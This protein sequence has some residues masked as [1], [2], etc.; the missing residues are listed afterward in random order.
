MREGKKHLKFFIDVAKI[1]WSSLYHVSHFCPYFFSMHTVC[2]GSIGPFYKVTYY[3]KSVT[4]SW[5]HSNCKGAEG[6]TNGKEHEERERE[7][8][9]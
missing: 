3:I 9:Y 6:K 2:P 1:F 7:E 4:T 5:T 8:R